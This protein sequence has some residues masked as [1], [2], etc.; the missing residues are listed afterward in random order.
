MKTVLYILMMLLSSLT[1]AQDQEAVFEQANT[2]YNQGKYAEAI[3]KYQTIL[4]SGLQSSELFF[5]LGNAHYKLNHVGPSVYYFEKAL[6]LAP[7]DTDIK[8][9]IAYAR[10][11]TIDAIDVVPEVGLTKLLKNVTGFLS[12]DGWAITT[13][14]LFVIFVVL[15]ISYYFAEYTAKKRFAFTTSIIVFFIGCL[16]LFFAFHDYNL[17][18]KDNPAII[19][20]QESQVKSEP[21]L[22]SQE[23]FIL[24]EGT[25]VQVLDTV[26]NW[27][28]IK[29]SDGKTGW[30]SSTDIKVL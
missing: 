17:T 9:N 3:D 4:D 12:F 14:M 22:S 30:V 7:N 10:N 16:T 24:H 26:N 13:V 20:V 27:K 6:Q 15:F 1:F 11:M 18:Q 25:K 8:N 21:N 28:K 29:L 19:F 2:L 5:N 23:A